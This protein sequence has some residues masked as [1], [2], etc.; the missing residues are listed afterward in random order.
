MI[1]KVSGME[2]VVSEGNVATWEVY[3]H[4]RSEA[5]RPKCNLQQPVRTFE[6][7]ESRVRANVLSLGSE[8]TCVGRL[9]EHI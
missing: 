5:S 9:L 4:S 8:T 2:S 7:E 6:K 3:R 1:Q